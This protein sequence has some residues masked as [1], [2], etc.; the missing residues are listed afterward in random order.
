M[1]ILLVPLN[2]IRYWPWY[3]RFDVITTVKVS[4]KGLTKAQHMFDNIRMTSID[5]SGLDTSKVRSDTDNP[6]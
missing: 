4:G 3:H 5:L 1:Q 6:F 2:Q